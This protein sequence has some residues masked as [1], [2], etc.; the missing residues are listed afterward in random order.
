ML[1]RQWRG[2]RRNGPRVVASAL[3]G[4]GREHARGHQV[5]GREAA[6][7]HEHLVPAL[8]RRRR[9]RKRRPTRS[10]RRSVRLLVAAGVEGATAAAER[11]WRRRRRQAAAVVVLHRDWSRLPPRNRRK[12]HQNSEEKRRERGEKKDRDYDSCSFSLRRGIGNPRQ[13][14]SQ[15]GTKLPIEP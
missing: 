15:I 12:N 10:W 7:L 8:R 11:R 13:T 5:L 1:L 6:G 4:G 9:R 3:Q 2:R 14:N